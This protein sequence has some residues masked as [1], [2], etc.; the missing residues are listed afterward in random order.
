MA[1]PSGREEGPSPTRVEPRVV[2]WSALVFALIVAGLVGLQGGEVTSAIGSFPIWAAVGAVVVQVGWLGCRG[3]AWR[4]ALNAVGP[5]EVPRSHA[6][7][8]NA[9]AFGAGAVQ[10]LA[11]VP[12]RALALRRLAPGSSPSLE[13]TLVADAPVLALEATLMG[14]ILVAALTTAPALPGWGAAAALAT[15]VLALLALVFLRERLGGRGLAAGLG[16]LADGRRRVKLAGLATIMGALGLSR[17]WL[18]LAGFE[19]PHGF[20]SAAFF[21]AALGLAAALP[22]GLASTPAAT[23]ALFGGTDAATATAAGVAMVTTS[24]LSV[25]LYGCISL[26]LAAAATRRARI[27]ARGEAPPGPRVGRPA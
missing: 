18:V 15:G 14:L 7:V 26:A 8:A 10:A 2:A 25:A 5:S 20:A 22:I 3:E 21:L 4:V 6:H 12:V 17:A 11:T 1:L 9:L 13:R 16:V 19:L 27:D 24:L 23:L